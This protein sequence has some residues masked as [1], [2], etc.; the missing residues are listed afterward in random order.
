MGKKLDLAGKTFGRLTVAAECDERSN[1][2]LVMWSCRCACGNE[3]KAKGASLKKG[4]T[5]SCGCSRIDHLRA[6]GEIQSTHGMSNTR[7]YQVWRGMMKRCHSET[8]PGYSNYGGRGISVCE[9]WH[10]FEAFY[11]DMG[12]PPFGM[13]IDRIDNNAG[14]SPENCRWAT[15]KEQANNRRTSIRVSVDGEQMSIA[16]VSSRYGVPLPT[17]YWR[18]GHGKAL[19]V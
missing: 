12:L 3:V 1:D 13:S 10:S 17:L 14:Y 7:I 16:E 4:D 18:N 9:R 19:I 6:L 15:P 5:R 8:D 2:G 11:R